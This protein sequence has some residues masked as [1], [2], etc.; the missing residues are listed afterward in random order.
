M[1][2]GKG[3]GKLPTASAV[4]ADVIDCVK[5]F[6]ARKYLFWDEG[7]KDYVE[8][9]LLNDVAMFV[10]AK[11]DDEGLAFKN[12]NQMFGDVTRLSIPKAEYGEIAF[13]TG[14]MQE[15]EIAA[16]LT[17]LQTLGVSVASTIRIGDL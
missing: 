5:H 4:V 10:R 13:V 3:A 8:D 17:E 11:T 15:K 14:T 16:K 6:K 9:Y 7:S 1:F 2:Y 12:I